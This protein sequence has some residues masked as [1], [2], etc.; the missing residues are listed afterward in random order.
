MSTNS[1]IC[2]RLKEC[3]TIKAVYCHFDGYIKHGVSEML[4]KHYN[5]YSKIYE[6][7]EHGSISSLQID[8]HPNKNKEHNINNYQDNVTV[9]F[10]DDM[11]YIFNA[12]TELQDMAKKMFIKYVYIYENDQ[13]YVFNDIFNSIE[14]EK[15]SS[16]FEIERGV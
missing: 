11:H 15:L 6:L 10:D 3:N 12:Y 14:L 9:F 8:I 5:N 4:Y 2:L 1:L 16:Y 13:W 7:L